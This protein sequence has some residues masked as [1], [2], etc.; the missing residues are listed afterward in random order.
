[1]GC[2]VNQC[3][4]TKAVTITT[5]MVI[6][7]TEDGNYRMYTTTATT[8]KEPEL[9][10]ELPEV[11]SGEAEAQFVLKYFPSAIAKITPTSTPE[12]G[13][14]S[15]SLSTGALA[16]IV[17]GAIAFLILV[18]VAAFIVIRHLNKVIAAVSVSKASTSSRPPMRYFK[19]TDSEVDAL[20]V[21]PLMMSPHPSHMRKES[22]IDGASSTDQTPNS[23]HAAMSTVNSQ[24]QSVGNPEVTSYFDGADGRFSQF[25]MRSRA[26][27]Q[28]MYAH[29]RH[30]SNA[31][32]DSDV[33]RPGAISPTG[34][35]EL[36][37]KEMAAELPGS[38]SSIGSHMEDALRRF[39]SWST[40]RPPNI[41]QRMRSGEIA[42]LGVVDEEIHG[43]YGPLDG[44]VGQTKTERP[45]SWHEGDDAK[46]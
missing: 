38:P 36:D 28:G 16:G 11:D 46:M 30:W 1:M 10:T 44:M 35:S 24:Y 23:F 26:E 7:T 18:I 17:T 34:M 2:A 32:E 41:H 22:A 12:E 33:G 27:S 29:V 39:S 9:P 42:G 15:G 3:Y 20:S 6:V 37:S 13:D 19:P 25:T 14:A 4:S 40:T 45:E 5:K 21:D 43:F 8:V 31:S